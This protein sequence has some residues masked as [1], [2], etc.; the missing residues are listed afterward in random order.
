MCS[1]S[2]DESALIVTIYQSLPLLRRSTERGKRSGTAGTSRD[3]G[4]PGLH[5][6]VVKDGGCGVEGL[7]KRREGWGGGATGRVIQHAQSSDR[8]S[9][10]SYRQEIAGADDFVWRQRS[11]SSTLFRTVLLKIDG[12]TPKTPSSN[13]IVGRGLILVTPSIIIC[14]A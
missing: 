3:R 11:G 7:G 12:D 5:M 9:H 14:A 8:E 13:T 6:I 4:T 10:R 1:P 2:Q